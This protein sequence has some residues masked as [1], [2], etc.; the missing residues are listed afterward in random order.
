MQFELNQ[1]QFKNTFLV[2]NNSNTN[3]ES[4]TKL[5]QLKTYFDNAIRYNFSK[6]IDFTA[7]ISLQ[8]N[9]FKTQVTSENI[10]L[11]NPTIS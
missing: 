2:N 8:N 7:N 10:F 6:K 9:V 3:Y 11:I 4:N 5:N 1:E